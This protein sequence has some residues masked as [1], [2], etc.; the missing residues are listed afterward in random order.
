MKNISLLRTHSYY[1]FLESLISPGDLVALAVKNDIQTL[2]L[3]DHRYLTG[4]LEFYESCQSAG[5]KPIIGLEIDLNYRGYLG[6]LTLLAKDRSGWSGLSQLST[7]ML[8]EDKPVSLEILRKYGSGLIAIAGD[9]RGVIR[10]LITKSPSSMNLPDL[11]IEEIKSI[12]Q[13]DFFMEVQRYPDGPLKNEHVLLGLAKNHNIKLIATQNIY[14]GKQSDFLFFQ[15]LSAIN[16]NTTLEKYKNEQ[17]PIRLSHFPTT[18]EFKHRFRDIPEALENLKFINERCNLAFPIGATQYPEFTTPGGISQSEYLEQQAFEGAKTIYQNLDEKIVDRLNYEL[19]IITEMG[20]E[21]IFLI[22]QD[23]INQAKKMG[24]PTSSRGSAASSLVAHCL[25][26]TSPDPISLD[27]YFERFLNPAR[28]KPPDID[29]DIA[30][31]HRDKVIQFVFDKY[32]A[33]R[34]AMVG[35]INRY[36]PKSALNDVAKVYGLSPETVR[37]LSKRLPSSFRFQRNGEGSNPFENLSN[38]NANPVIQNIIRDARAILDIPRHLSVHPGGI[39]I[40]PFQITDLVPLTQSSSLGINHTQFDLDGIEKLG[41]VKIDL[42]GI[43]GLTVLGEVAERVR[44]W[45]LSEFKTSLSVLDSIP[46]D[47][48]ETERT[49]REAKTIGC[50]QIESPG[51]RAT[52]QEIEAKNVED[53]MAALAL[54]RPGPLRG[55]LRDAF[56]RR[57]RGEEAID[58]IH[59]S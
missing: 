2:G 41:L 55:G 36:R 21:P 3:T 50:F 4:A 28:K 42:L 33:D 56:V 53:I 27:L 57:F 52:L 44:S 9:H 37:H 14:Y 24:I 20:Y 17:D 46:K 48:P 23:I 34:V 15:T 19:N 5:I 1:G 58:H 51:M 22:V 35:T 32:G 6:I 45:R 39:V 16:R 38:S 8:V 12:F 11:Y 10:E 26:I 59:P 30:S 40:A 29:T 31:H 47:D 43:R 25:N 18:Y 7:H 49:V 13:D 54:Y